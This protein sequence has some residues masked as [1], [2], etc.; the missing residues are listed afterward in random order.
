MNPIT[1]PLQPEMQGSA[2]ADLQDA[3]LLLISHQLIKTFPA[4]SQPTVEE[5]QV[6]TQRLKQER[7]QSTFGDATRQMT[8]TSGSSQGE[9]TIGRAMK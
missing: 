4:P 1:F 7:T 3:L 2:V 5:L 9:T 6:L 8:L